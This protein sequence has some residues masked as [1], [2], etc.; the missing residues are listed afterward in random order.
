MHDFSADTGLGAGTESMHDWG[1]RS[2]PSD[3]KIQRSSLRSSIRSS[4][5]RDTTGRDTMDRSE[6]SITF[7]PFVVLLDRD[8]PME[9]HEERQEEIER[10]E[11]PDTARRRRG[12]RRTSSGGVDGRLNTMIQISPLNNEGEDASTSFHSESDSDSEESLDFAAAL[13]SFVS[14]K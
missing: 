5:R 1:Y 8:V 12:R 6:R 3:N 13:G 2:L 9:S 7:S 4:S 14:E 11:T 10:Q